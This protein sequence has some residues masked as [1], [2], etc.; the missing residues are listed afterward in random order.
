MYYPERADQVRNIKQRLR[1][2]YADNDLRRYTQLSMQHVPEWL[3]DDF[4]SYLELKVGLHLLKKTLY[5][6]YRCIL[7][8]DLDYNL[9]P[10]DKS[11]QAGDKGRGLRLRAARHLD[12]DTR[13][14][15]RLRAETATVKAFDRDRAEGYEFLRRWVV[16]P[17]GEEVQSWLKKRK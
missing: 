6:P 15:G 3:R 10:R 14:D 4:V 5:M 8:Y 13:E 11:E 17:E 12:Y 9:Q 2:L 1:T 16:G 7:L